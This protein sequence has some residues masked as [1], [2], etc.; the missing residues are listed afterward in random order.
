[1]KE[2]KSTKN[3]VHK[4]KEKEGLAKTSSPN[5]H[6]ISGMKT[7]LKNNIDKYYF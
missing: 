3:L 5:A 7:P 4:R 6:A 2:L 1:M